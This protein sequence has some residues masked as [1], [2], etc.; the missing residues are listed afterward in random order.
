MVY[1]TSGVHW[2][3]TYVSHHHDVLRMKSTETDPCLLFRFNEKDKLD[4]LV[5]LQVDGSIG[6]GSENFHTEEDKASKASN[7]RDRPG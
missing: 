6:A 5:C 3:E 1:P 2:F 4:G 7:L